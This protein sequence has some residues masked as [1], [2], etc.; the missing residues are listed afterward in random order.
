MISFMK[1][2]FNILPLY[3]R[4]RHH[5][6][7]GTNS[8]HEWRLALT[9]FLF[10]K[11]YKEERVIKE[12]EVKFAEKVITKFAYS[13]GAGRMALYAILEALE[14]SEGDEIIVPAYTCVVVP[15]AVL[16]RGAKPIYVDIERES[17]N[18]DVSKIEEA[19]TS[20]TK[21]IFAQHTFGLPCDLDVI[22]EIA[23]KHNLKVI[24]DCAHAL[25]A[26]YKGRPVGGISD[27]AFFSTDHSKI[28]S[29][30]LGGMVT[31]SDEEIARKIKAIQ[32]KAPFL[33][34]KLHRKLMLGFLLEFPLYSAYTYWL[35]K[36]S[37]AVLSKLGCI[38]YWRDE[39]LHKKPEDYPYP[40]RLSAQQ[41]QI[42]ISQ[43]QKLE[44]NIAHRRSVYNAIDDA[45]KFDVPCSSESA[46]LR[47][48][49]YVKNRSEFESLFLTH[50]DLGIWFTSIVQ[51]KNENLHEIYYNEGSCPNAE[52]AAKHL[53]NFPTHQRTPIKFV[54]NQLSKHRTWIIDNSGYNF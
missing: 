43:L 1:K 14:I 11:D 41:A 31:T 17:C 44:D 47:Y 21:A 39:H 33:P 28:T 52:Y 2:I 36:F 22:K 45:L 16:Y 26:S 38:F 51:G 8:W 37:L 42:G 20:K 34:A 53:V 48:S 19:I 32:Q 40:A 25:G 9:Q 54:K 5:I 12:Y 15:N 49:F 30:F 27:V 10:C 13:F 24:E 4:I 3:P 7:S 23:S 50:W 29:T 46:C 18:I 35:G 6:F